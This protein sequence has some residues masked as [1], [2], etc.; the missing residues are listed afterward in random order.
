MAGPGGTGKASKM[1]GAMP[2]TFL[3][4]FP[5]PRG[6]PDLKNAP[7][8]SGQTA[9]K[10]PGQGNGRAGWGAHAHGPAHAAFGMA[11]Q[12]SQ[13]HTPPRLEELARH[14][15]K[16]QRRPYGT[17]VE[18]CEQRNP[19]NDDK[20]TMSTKVLQKCFSRWRQVTSKHTLQGLG[21]HRATYS[22]MASTTL[23]SQ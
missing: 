11:R 1:W 22:D 3:R 18:P 15:T 20:H 4:A 10:Y 23:N 8:K 14:I 16:G 17:D 9:F 19:H 12:T 13:P 5:G 6:R 7:T 21:G 2:P